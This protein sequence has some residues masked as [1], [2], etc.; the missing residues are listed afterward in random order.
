VDSDV[1]PIKLLQRKIIM[2]PKIKIIVAEGCQFMRAGIAERLIKA[3]EDLLLVGEAA[4]FDEVIELY[5]RL[6]PQLLILALNSPSAESPFRIAAISQACPL[7]SILIL[8]PAYG[9]WI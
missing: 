1:L 5:Q 6:K 7:L 3:Q 4:R 9:G 2:K 8:T